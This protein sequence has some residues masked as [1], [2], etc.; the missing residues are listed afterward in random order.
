MGFNKNLLL[1]TLGLSDFRDEESGE[2]EE[3]NTLTHDGTSAGSYAEFANG[4]DMGQSRFVFMMKPEA[5]A[6]ISQPIY[7]EGFVAME[8]Y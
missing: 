6:D 2:Y 4:D 3:I 5:F 7:Y 1:S 8:V